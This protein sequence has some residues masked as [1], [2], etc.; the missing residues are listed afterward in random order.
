ML[1]PTF[2]LAGGKE[3][4]LIKDEE[5]STEQGSNQID[6]TITGEEKAESDQDIAL[7]ESDASETR[8]EV[9]LDI[10]SDK[11]EVEFV[12]D[13]T[14]DSDVNKTLEVKLSIRQESEEADVAIGIEE[15]N[16]ENIQKISIEG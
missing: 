11:S 7:S 10:E 13:T 6:V 8:E 1:K 3:E 9:Q 16:V 14:E 15:E 5:T 4:F 12:V 2:N